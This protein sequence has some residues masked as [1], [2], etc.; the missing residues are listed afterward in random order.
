MRKYLVYINFNIFFLIFNSFC[1]SQN[2]D[3]LKLALKNAKHDTARCNILAVLAETAGEDEWPLFNEQLR[4]LAEKNASVLPRDHSLKKVYLKLYAVALNN[5][6][7]LYDEQGDIP[8]ALE[9]YFA[10]IKIH[11]QIENKS[12]IASS[13]NNIG[14]IYKNQGNIQ[15]A[16]EYY[17]KSLMIKEEI[18]DKKGISKSLSN[19]GGIYRDQ[20]ESKK[21]LEYYYRSLDILMEI[22]DKPSIGTLLNNIGTIYNTQQDLQKALD[23]YYKSLKLREEIGDK[24]GIANSYGNIANIYKKQD[25]LLKALEYHKK[26]LKIYEETGE[27]KGQ[28]SAL[29]NMAQIMTK[30]GQLNNALL[31]A[32]RSMQTAKEL[33]FPEYI[34]RSADVIKTVYQKQN[35][36]KE[37]FEMYELEIKMRDSINNQ[38]T[39]KESIK[40]QMQYTYEKKELETKAE[41]EKKDAIANE[42]KQKQKVITYSVSVGLFLV[43]LLTLFIFRGLRQKQKANLIIT[44]Q[45]IEVES[46]KH[47]IEEKHKEIT[48][49]INYAERIQRSFI[50]TKEILDEN[51]NDYFVYFKPKDVVSGDFYWSGKLNNGNF[52]FVTADSTGHGVPGA[53]MSLLNITSLEKAIETLNEP[54]EILNATR[55]TIIERLKKDGSE[56]GGKD[57]MDASLTVYDFKTKKLQIAAANN[58]VWIVRTTSSNIGVNELELIEIKPDKMPVGKHDRDNVSFTQQ[59]IQLQ[60]G[61]VVYTLT[62]GFPDQFGGEKGKKFMSKNLKELLLSN[63]HLA[64]HQQK[65]LLEKTFTH[66]K[67]NLEQVDDV[68]V[69]GIKI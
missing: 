56:H 21:A 12:G 62:D 52:A 16:L 68:T 26:S 39:R 35:K 45:K 57:G 2:I 42:E 61:D 41:Q 66:W 36:Y 14:F 37:A 24:S 29:I 47:Y 43:L 63:A 69:I 60:S 54:A 58:P 17:H 4:V 33:G 18:G 53:I 50:A 44:Q 8:K 38:E 20:G 30:N 28:A 64:M 49:S 59:Q 23:Y 9:Y 46:Q 11:E 67:S 55:K 5:F 27:K 51:L 65:Q 31:Y 10:S 48:D 40:K 32:S 3:S 15:K 1:F 19:L 34:F 22:A 7:F 13:L 6:G 25:D